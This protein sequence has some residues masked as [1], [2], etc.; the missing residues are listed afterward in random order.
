MILSSIINII[1]PPKCLV[2]NKEGKV[3]CSECWQNT[4]ALRKSAC[5]LCNKLNDD[6]KT[7]SN[8][9]RKSYLL[10]ATIPY[11]LQDIVK[12][13]IYQLKYYSNVDMAKFLA[14]QIADFVPQIHFDCICFVP[15]TGKTQRKR[16]YNQSKLIAKQVSKVLHIPISQKL[17]RISHVDQIGLDRQQRFAVVADNFILQRACTNQNILLIDDV[18]TTGAT[19]NEC[20]KVLK[21]AG[22]KKVWVLAVAKK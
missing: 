1:S 5:F 14:E 22:A 20:T 6:G 2:C 10:G 7:C 9:R 16:G 12:E 21:N 18:I 13:S 11:R 8:C 4:T 3:M 15:S 17:I 19:V